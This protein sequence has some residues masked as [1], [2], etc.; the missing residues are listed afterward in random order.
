MLASVLEDKQ[1]VTHELAPGRHAWLQVVRGSVLIE[2]AELGE[3]D[4]ASFSEV[5]SIAI[6]SAGDS[7]LLLFDLA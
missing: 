7:E 1:R 6:E 4:A 2:G 3:G 5:P